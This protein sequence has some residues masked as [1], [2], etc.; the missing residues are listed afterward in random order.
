MQLSLLEESTNFKFDQIYKKILI[1][2]SPN[3]FN[4]KIYY[5]II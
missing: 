2:M 4:M 1:F 5:M 3:R